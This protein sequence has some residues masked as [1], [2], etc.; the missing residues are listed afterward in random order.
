MYM[1]MCE[2]CAHSFKEDGFNVKSFANKITRDVC[3]VCHRK[4]ICSKHDVR[5]TA[6][7]VEGERL[8]A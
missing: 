5:L 3:Q 2:K 1:V 6:H 8:E 4:V 7:S